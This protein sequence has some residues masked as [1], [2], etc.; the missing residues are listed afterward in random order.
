MGV[1][2]RALGATL[3]RESQDLVRTQIINIPRGEH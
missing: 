2:Q 3:P 1:V